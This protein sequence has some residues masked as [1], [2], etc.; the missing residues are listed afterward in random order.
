MN[1]LSNQSTFCAV[2]KFF[3]HNLNP[4][5]EELSFYS[6]TNLFVM[7]S[8]GEI[9]FLPEKSQIGIHYIQVYAENNDK[10]FAIIELTV[11]WKK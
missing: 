10:D 9:I 6:D 1:R 4:N 7:D 8:T 3:R 2:F 11:I 5:E